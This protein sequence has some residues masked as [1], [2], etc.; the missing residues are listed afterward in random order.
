VTASSSIRRSS[1]LGGAWRILLVPSGP[2]LAEP[3]TERS[4]VETGDS[5]PE[6]LQTSGRSDS[7]RAGRWLVLP[8]IGIRRNW[9]RAA[10]G[11]GAAAGAGGGLGLG[12]VA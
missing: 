8:D 4:S 11:T 6:L 9:D 7:R 2:V 5:V 3:A 12:G 10:S 1:D